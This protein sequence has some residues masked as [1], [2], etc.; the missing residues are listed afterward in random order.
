M[1]GD[2]FSNKDEAFQAFDDIPLSPVGDDTMGAVI[3]RR[4]GRRDILKGSLAVTA[5]TALFGTAALEGASGPARAAG[6]GFD[7]RELAAGVDETHHVAEGYVADVVIRWG[8]P[9]AA[10]MKP[11]DPR[12]LTGE[13]QARR[14]GYNNDY[15]AYFPLDT[16]NT[17]GLLC[18]NNEYA[19]PEVMFPGL[20][21]R[22]DRDDFAKITEAHVAVEMA[23]HGVS[24][25]EIALEGGKWT[26]VVGSKYNRRITANTPMTVDGPAA[27]HDRLRT[28]ADPTGR[29]LLGTLNNCAGGQTP[30]GTYLTGEENCNGYFWTDQKTADGKRLTK[31]LGGDQQKSYER[32]GIPSNWYSWG[33]YHERF[34]VDKEANEC[35]RFHWI[36]EI[37]PMDPASKPVKHTALG[38]FRHEGAEMILNTD[39]RV[40]VY[41][42]DDAQLDYVY[43]FVSKEKVRQGDKAHNMRLLSE[44]TL[45]VA[46]FNEDGSV[47]WLPLVFG[48]GP[49]TAEKGFTSQ[50]EILIDTRLAADA[51]KA[52]R[53]DRPE[54]VQPA[55]GTGKVYIMLTNNERRRPEEV[56]KANPRPQNEFGHIIEMTAPDGDHAAATFTWDMLIKCGDPR[57]AEVGAMWNPA[58]SADGWFACPDN[59]TID[60]LGRLWVATDQG[61]SWPKTGRADGIYAVSTEGQ[62]RGTSKLFFR[63]PVGAEMCGPCLTPDGETFFVAVQ[64]PS[65]DGVRNWKPFG[66]ESTF[67]D[68]AT[69]WPDFKPDMPPRPSV[70]AIRKKGGGKI[71]SG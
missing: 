23:A 7:F 56:D 4:S 58:T 1:Q 42:G 17:R 13:E 6:A 67:E 46:R 20:T 15:I 12:T 9:L 10:D 69:R 70:V 33:K 25:V 28:K 63:V 49:L 39:G 3:A 71:A 55:P 65:T 8:D 50:A 36:V 24:I 19:N 54:D 27:G 22:P 30:W 26:P 37:D 29:N 62:S 40:V 60:A 35:N 34:N 53:M 68:P 14:F 11:F 32:Y 57:V 43:R 45:S 51:L 52:T 31:G 18:V 61:N 2:D 41:T 59:C 38:R 44:G 47:Q 21:V 48:E 16:S 64:H 66:R 5:A